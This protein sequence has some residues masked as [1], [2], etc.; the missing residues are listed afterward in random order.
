MKAEAETGQFRH[1]PRSTRGHQ[2]LEEA[3]GILPWNLGT[4]RGPDDTLISDF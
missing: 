1:K 2:E 3:G 4:E